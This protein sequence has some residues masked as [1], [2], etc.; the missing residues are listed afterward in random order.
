MFPHPTEAAALA[1]RAAASLGLVSAGVDILA[2]DLVADPTQATIL[3]V[4]SAP[5]LDYFATEN[6]ETWLRARAI[7]TEMLRLRLR[8]AG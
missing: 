4:N 8:A 5:G 6:A 7:V 2:P 3:E 1:T